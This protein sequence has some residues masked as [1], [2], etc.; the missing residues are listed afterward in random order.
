MQSYIANIHITSHNNVSFLVLFAWKSIYYHHLR[1][2]YLTTVNI[3]YIGAQLITPL[4]EAMSFAGDG[5]LSE[6]CPCLENVCRIIDQMTAGLKEIYTL[7]DPDIFFTEVR[8]FIASLQK[9]E[10]C[11]VELALRSYHGGSAA[12]S[13]LLQFIDA[14]LCVSYHHSPATQHY[15]H[16]MRDYMPTEHAELIRK[17]ESRSSLK[18]CAQKSPLLNQWYRTCLNRLIAFRNEHLNIVGQYI[19]APAK[20][21]GTEALGT[22]GTNPMT[23]LRSV[24]DWLLKVMKN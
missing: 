12:Q 3:E 11:G 24:R 9:V 18:D 6:A 14:A 23:F 21:H 5:L 1:K 22:G 20:R 15:L 8:P 13:S 10:F 2:A 7:V 17:I 16:A 19:M 4:M